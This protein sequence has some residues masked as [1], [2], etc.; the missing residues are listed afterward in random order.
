MGRV[1]QRFVSAG[2]IGGWEQCKIGDLGRFSKGC[3]YSKADL[4][5]NGTSIILYGRLYTNYQTVI[6]EVN[7]YALKKKNAILSKGNDVIVPASG[8][9]ADDR[10][11]KSICRHKARRFTGW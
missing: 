9:T 10:Y 11:C 5:Q 3:G 2:F 4:V 7:T 6:S 1:C 8:E